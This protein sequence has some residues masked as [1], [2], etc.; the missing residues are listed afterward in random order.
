M[1]V[2]EQ[3]ALL[4]V[5]YAL[6]MLPHS[7]KISLLAKEFVSGEYDNVE[8]RGKQQ[9]AFLAKDTP[10]MSF[11]RRCGAAHNNTLECFPF[12]AAAI[13][14]CVLC[15]ADAQ[16]T[17]SLARRYTIGRVLYII[18]YLVGAPNAG[19]TGRAI[20]LL[21]TLFY[22]D[23]LNTVWRLFGHALKKS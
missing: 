4:P 3:L 12:I 22:M 21:R 11:I 7:V 15:K 18:A 1:S 19:A 20:A 9:Q 5:N 10:K 6:T 16:Q 13:V 2:P 14:S 17:I 8:P 23:N